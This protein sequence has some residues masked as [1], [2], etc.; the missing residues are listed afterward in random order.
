MSHKTFKGDES[1]KREELVRPE[2][3]FAYLNGILGDSS[4]L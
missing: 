3:A 2:A 4:R 1:E